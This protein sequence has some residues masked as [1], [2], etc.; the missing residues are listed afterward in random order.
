[1]EPGQGS[2]M[3]S[4]T[5]SS[6][7][8]GGFRSRG[9]VRCGGDFSVT[10]GGLYNIDGDAMP[11]MVWREPGRLEVFK[12]KGGSTLGT[13]EAGKLVDIGNGYGGS[14]SI[15]YCSAKKDLDTTHA[16]PYPETVV[17]AVAA[18]G[19]SPTYTAYGDIKMMFDPVADD[20]VRP[21]MER[22]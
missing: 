22:W 15:Q 16:V 5:S 14:T 4:L 12:L 21:D 2:E 18:T 13:P 3:E 8:L 19:Q 20:S 7:H 9:S 17:C 6:I 10:T 1:M 11:A